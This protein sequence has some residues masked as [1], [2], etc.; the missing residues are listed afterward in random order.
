M[1][2]DF[3]IAKQKLKL[4]GIV[5][6]CEDFYMEPIRKNNNIYFAKSPKT[7][8]T[9]ES[10]ALYA[11]SDRFCDF[12]NGSSS[13]DCIGFIGYIHD[14]NNWQALKMLQDYYHLS[15]SS[16]RDRRSAVNQIRRQKRI[17]QA[18]SERKRQFQNALN[19]EFNEQ[20]DWLDIYK[21][22]IENSLFGPLSD[23][24]C[25]CQN[26]R[27]KCEYKLSVLCAVN[28][29][30]YIRLKKSGGSLPTDRYKWLSDAIEILEE[31]GR[32]FA[33]EGELNEL[34]KQA[35][36]EVNRKKAEVRRCDI[37]W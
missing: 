14:V 24:W 8:D 21:Y 34:Q 18:K 36:F 35:D 9:T 22:C 1:K 10:L 27:Q 5:R 6:I 12:A 16:E 13:G 19:A 32:F 2:E 20:K 3:I 28:Q 29:M 26:M 30:E 37:D 7:S 4:I 11:D 33:T 17:E 15:S 25:D 23:A 31:S